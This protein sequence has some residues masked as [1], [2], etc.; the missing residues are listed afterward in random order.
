[1]AEYQRPR[2]QMETLFLLYLAGRCS[3][4]L[5]RVRSPALCKSDPG[6]NMVSRRDQLLLHHVSLVIYSSP[7]RR[8]YATKCF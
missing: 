4:N 6:N 1:M 5:Q 7:S 3:E 8:F 2:A